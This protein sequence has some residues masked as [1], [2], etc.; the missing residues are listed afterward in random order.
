MLVGCTEAEKC[1]QRSIRGIMFLGGFF[2]KCSIE[3]VSCL[4]LNL[5][6][7]HKG[8]S[9]PTLERKLANVFSAFSPMNPARTL[10]DVLRI[11]SSVLVDISQDFVR[12][13]NTLHLVSFYEMERTRIAP[14]LNK[15]VS[16]LITIHQETPVQY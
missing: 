16:L 12:R 1:V 11:K 15:R 14:F 10:I 3:E 6:T 4:I 7:P 2:H 9:L 5:G 8:G 13:R